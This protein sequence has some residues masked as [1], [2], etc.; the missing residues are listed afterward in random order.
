MCVLIPA[1]NEER[2]IGNTLEGVLQHID[3]IVV[4]N[5]GSV[6]KTAE[7]VRQYPVTLIN[8]KENRG[9]ARWRWSNGSFK[10]N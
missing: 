2:K 9:L 4:V 6:D 7:I 8:R 10:T 1:Y 3:D 5:D